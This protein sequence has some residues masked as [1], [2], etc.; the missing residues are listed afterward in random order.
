MPF[1]SY[2]HFHLH[3]A[4]LD[5]LCLKWCRMASLRL[6]YIHV[7]LIHDLQY[8]L[9]GPLSQLILCLLHQYVLHPHSTDRSYQL[10]YNNAAPLLLPHLDDGGLYPNPSNFCNGNIVLLCHRRLKG[11]SPVTLVKNLSNG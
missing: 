3:L 6:Q 5:C 2:K 4:L 11:R 8:Q 10:V 7:Q 1:S 9:D